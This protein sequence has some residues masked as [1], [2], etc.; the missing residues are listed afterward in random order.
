[1]EDQRG[2]LTITSA[3]EDIIPPERK[4][5]Y[6]R[7]LPVVDRGRNVY[8]PPETHMGKAIPSGDNILIIANI[9]VTYLDKLVEDAA[10]L[11]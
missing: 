7:L 9:A 1:M 4:F 11:S 6:V 8:K 3:G 5:P 10:I 2:E